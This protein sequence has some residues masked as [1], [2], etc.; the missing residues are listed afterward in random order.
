[1]AD[2][3]LGLLGHMGIGTDSG[4]WENPT[5]PSYSIIPFISESLTS[6]F[7]RIPH[8]S[9][10]GYG[11]ELPSV[12]G[13]EI[14]QGTTEHYL[15]Y[16]TMAF[17]IAACMGNDSGS[18]ITILDR[19]G[20][21]T[22]KRFW[23]IMDKGHTVYRFGPGIP[24]KMTISGEKDGRI[25]IALEWTFFGFSTTGT[26]WSATAYVPT[27]RMLFEHGVFRFADQ[28]NAL[29]SGDAI[30][31]NSFETT[32]DRG[33]IT[34]D[35]VMD[36]T[37]PKNCLQPVENAFRVC[38]LKFSI[39]RYDA[40]TIG[41]WKQAD[42]PLQADLV[43]T[44]GGNSHTFQWR[45]LRIMDGFDA[46]IDGSTAITQEGT[47]QSYRCANGSHPMGIGNELVV[48]YT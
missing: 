31:I 8:D 10:V 23:M 11:G 41:G 2:A 13:I 40:D 38:E 33:M 21:G 39:P 22:V 3:S 46:P 35:Y 45:E 12:Q 27:P 42:T 47:C 14:V 9:L 6:A 28:L 4:V 44:L 48:N 43:F 26:P 16:T 30:G 37:Y 25:K 20:S 15:D 18:S 5:P 1:M 24:H 29:A 19:H 32:L 7:N 36:A 17:M 34:D